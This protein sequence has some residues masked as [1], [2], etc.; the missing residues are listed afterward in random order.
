MVSNGQSGM[1]RPLIGRRI[2]IGSA[3]TLLLP[4]AKAPKNNMISPD[5]AF[6]GATSGRLLLI[7]IRRPAEWCET[8]IARP[9]TPLDMRRAKFDEILLSLVGGNRARR[10]ALI[11]A[12][13]G[14]SSTLARRLR[15]AG[16]ANILDVSGGMKGGWY[17]KGWIDLGLPLRKY[18]VAP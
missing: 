16:F 15:S 13:G 17:S 14:R 12:S 4:G 9:A 2:F 6:R 8:G 11:C 5:D 1:A 10:I 7:D 3:A 18:C